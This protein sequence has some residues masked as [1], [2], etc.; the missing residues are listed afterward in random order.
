MNAML[1]RLDHATD[2]QRRFVADASH[3]LRSPLT[4]IRA[5]LEVD[6]AHPNGADWQATERD[7]LDDAIRMQHLVDDLLALAASD[8]SATPAAHE[9]VD[10]DEIVLREARRLRSRTAHRIDTSGV[11]GAQLLGDSGGLSRAVRNLLDNAARHARSTVTVTLS[12]SD[13]TLELSI[14]DDGP[15]IPPDQHERVFERFA[16][17]DDGRARDDGG[18]GLGLAIT[19]DVVVAHR[20]TITVD[21]APGA[22]FT[23]RIPLG[24]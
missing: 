5:R 1:R 10:L 22:R 11:S 18:T 2:R 14:A 13:T 16:R 24:P 20:G 19:H 8:A 23:I 21:N 6:L 4:G 15:G 12:E 17:L 7:V 3:E 9:P